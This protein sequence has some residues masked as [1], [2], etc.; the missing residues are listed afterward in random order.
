MCVFFNLWR[1][2][3]LLNSSVLQACI[4]MLVMCNL[5]LLSCLEFIDGMFCNQ[6]RFCLL[7][8]EKIFGKV[9]G[10]AVDS[11][12]LLLY[13][14]FTACMYFDHS[15]N[16]CRAAPASLGQQNVLLGFSRDH[17]IILNIVYISVYIF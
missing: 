16:V 6:L 7:C 15:L 14:E 5:A 2:N 10:S 1:G 8:P 13:A 4:S 11:D 12:Q 17:M 9:F 3:Y